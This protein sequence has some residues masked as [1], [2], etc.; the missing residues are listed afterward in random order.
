MNTSSGSTLSQKIIYISF[1]FIIVSPFIQFTWNGYLTKFHQMSACWPTGNIKKDAEIL[2]VYVF[3][4]FAVYDIDIKCIRYMNRCSSYNKYVK[5]CDIFDN[6]CEKFA[7][8]CECE[9][10]NT[11]HKIIMYHNTYTETLI[12]LFHCHHVLNIRYN[13][14]L[15]IKHPNGIFI[16]LK[17]WWWLLG[18]CVCIWI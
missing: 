18:I 16:V 14:F 17:W 7:C 4:V 15:T 3:N 2:F 5:L 13:I 9:C 12:H 11:D 1:N 10:K 6:S 8:V